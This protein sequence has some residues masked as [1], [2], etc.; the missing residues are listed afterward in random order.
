MKRETGRIIAAALLLAVMRSVCIANAQQSGTVRL[1]N[2]TSGVTIC[3]RVEVF[4]DGEWGTVCD[5]RWNLAGG[6]VVCKQLG[7]VK[8]EKIFYTAHFGR[9]NGPIWM[10]SV[11]CNE[12]QNSLAECR[13]NGW[14]V[15]D[16]SHLEDAGV[17]CEREQAEKPDSLPVRLRCPKCNE[18]GLCKA[19]PHKM[20]PDPT[21]CLPQGTVK[22]IVEVQVNGVWGTVSGEGWGWTEASVVCGQL[23]YPL[24]YISSTLERLWP[25]YASGDEASQCIGK[26]LE[27]T[28]S[29]RNSLTNTLLQGVDCSGKEGRLRE[30]YIARVGSEPNPSRK[31][32]TVQCG[33][34][35]H[36]DCYSS[37]F[38]EVT[39]RIFAIESI[40]NCII[41]CVEMYT[42]IDLSVERRCGA[43]EWSYRGQTK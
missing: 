21:E 25:N 9:G 8:A 26:D 43:V 13:H 12:G 17:C 32:A 28:A 38:S 27:E 24:A 18:G 34:F 2:S 23:G 29:L 7:Y 14:G 36:K 3:G 15:H 1:A 39:L 20:H 41:Y 30:C 4:H 19:C 6:N 10:D 37:F 31:V 5:D 40:H 16:C 35:P 42:H 22:G 33:F 11:Q